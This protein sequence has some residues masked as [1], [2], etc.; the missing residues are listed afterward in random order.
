[1]IKVCEYLLMGPC[2]GVSWSVDMHT[3]EHVFLCSSVSLTLVT[4]S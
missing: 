3:S 4:D 2:A 1:M